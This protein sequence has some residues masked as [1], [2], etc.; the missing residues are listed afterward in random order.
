MRWV[1]YLFLLLYAV[2]LFL[3]AV[4]TFGWFGQVRD[5]LSGVFL[6]PLGLPWI[7]LG[8]AAG[9]TGPALAILAPA[10]NPASCTGCGNAERA[11]PPVIIASTRT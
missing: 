8:D 3:L 4:G 1:F 2:A 11:Q 9:L 6:I 7:W 5:P 10:I